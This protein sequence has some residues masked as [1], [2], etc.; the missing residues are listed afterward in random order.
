M[1][2]PEGVGGKLE[3][4]LLCCLSYSAAA[5]L[6]LRGRG[7]E[8][9]PAA[10]RAISV[11]SSPASSPLT[12]RARERGRDTDE[13]LLNAGTFEVANEGFTAVP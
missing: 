10:P 3:H 7:G 6:L 1:E 11:S 12:G 8:F 5:G 4:I 2:A 9:P 13:L